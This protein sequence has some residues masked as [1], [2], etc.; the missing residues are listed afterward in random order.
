MFLVPATC[1]TQQLHDRWHVHVGMCICRTAHLLR[2]ACLQDLP[3]GIATDVAKAVMMGCSD[4]AGWSP[5]EAKDVT[6]KLAASIT[7]N[8]TVYRIAEFACFGT[9]R[10]A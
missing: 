5:T 3:P 4:S 10:L 7:S 9:Y 6:T 1:S 8:T 2:P